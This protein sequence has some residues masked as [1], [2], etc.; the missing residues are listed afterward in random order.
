MTTTVAAT[1]CATVVDEWVRAGVTEA[2]VAPGSR[3][4]PMALALA[5]NDKI[6][7][8]VFV[9][10][11]SAA[12]AALGHGLAAGRPAVVL[13]TSGTAAAHFH[14]AI[15]EADLSSVP[16]IACTADRPA[17]LWD[18]GAPQ[19]IDQ[20][21][22]YGPTV[23]FYAE[24][25]VPDDATATSWRSVASRTVAE[26]KGW[27][28]R[29]GPVHLNLSFRDP[30]VGEPGELPPGRPD[31]RTWHEVVAAGAALASS[32]SQIAGLVDT[33]IEQGEARRGVIVAGE[34]TDSPETVLELA[35]RL[36]WP[37]LADHRSGCRA[38]GRAVTHFDAMLRSASF[39]ERAAPELVLRFGEALSSKVLGEWI[40]AS[41]A[42]VISVVDRSR[43]TNPERAA[44]RVVAAGGVARK[45][46]DA[47]PEPLTAAHTAERWSK[48]AAVADQVV[49]ET[50]AGL[51]GPDKLT[52]I[53]VARRVINDLPTDGA[54]MVSSSMPVRDVE[55]FGPNRNDVTVLANRGANGIDGVVSTAI[56]VASTGR[57]TTVL[58]GDV[59][60]VHDSTA[61][62]GLAG[63]DIDLDIVVIDNNGGGIFSFLPQAG[64]LDHDVFE[65]LFGTPHHT[66]I[67]ALAGAHGI[68]ATPWPLTPQRKGTG[69]RLTIAGTERAANADVHQTVNDAV[70]A[71]LDDIR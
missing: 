25:G 14:A 24:P 32:D 22:L 2:F 9:D 16:L 27:A 48:A 52:E 60:F 47:L 20:S 35:E 53:E 59:A 67:H 57:P 68:T 39:A 7:T 55:W 31:G 63:R 61:L 49:D 46:L 40:S 1:F 42:E 18:I 15:I 12:F 38:P 28:G 56:G 13:C 30:L 5:A 62:V 33:M 64:Q 21:K 54:L 43:W 44:G 51:G 70:A 45:L 3:S 8:L 37:V 4:T 11:R 69:V 65:L 66:D 29:A 58:I 6:R 36:G 23:R 10:E 19:T 41:E 50:L 26:A 17:E 34:G 71:A